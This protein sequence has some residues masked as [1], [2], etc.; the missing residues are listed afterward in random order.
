MLNNKEKR[1]ALTNKETRIIVTGQELN[2]IALTKLKK[3]L[4]MKTYSS[5]LLKQFD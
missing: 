5:S 4:T 3:M 2:Q 1:I